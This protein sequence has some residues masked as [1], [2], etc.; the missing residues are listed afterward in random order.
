MIKNE[1]KPEQLP[2]SAELQKIRAA[3]RRSHKGILGKLKKQY[4]LSITKETALPAM[5]RLTDLVSAGPVDPG[6]RLSKLLAKRNRKINARYHTLK[7]YAGRQGGGG[8][9]DM[10]MFGLFRMKFNGCEVMAVYNLMRY[11]GYKT[12]IRDIAYWFETH[13][14]ML[15]GGFGVR[16]D[17]IVNYLKENTDAEVTTLG[18]S[19]FHEYDNLFAD[20]KAAVFSFWNGPDKWTIHTVML[21]HLR[22]GRVRVFNMFNDRLYSDFDSVSAMCSKNKLIPISMILISENCE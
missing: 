11:L 2:D 19:Q 17:A 5:Q 15:L 22:N 8:S 6:G 12:D 10:L 7:S 18:P 4:G 20:A 14:S 3:V 16:P 1:K 13:G 21:R 9:C